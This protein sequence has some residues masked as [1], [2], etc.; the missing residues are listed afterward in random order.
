M[1]V[2]SDESVCLVNLY[3]LMNPVVSVEPDAHVGSAVSTASG[4]NE[5]IQPR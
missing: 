4:E 1:S 3:S 2:L 5:W